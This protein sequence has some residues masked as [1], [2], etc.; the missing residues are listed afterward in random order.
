MTKLVPELRVRVPCSDQMLLDHIDN[1]GTA[2]HCVAVL[3]EPVGDLAGYIMSLF[4]LVL[5][6]T[7]HTS[8]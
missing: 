4:G 5:T 6:Y 3:R 8:L 7:G 2:R 1:V